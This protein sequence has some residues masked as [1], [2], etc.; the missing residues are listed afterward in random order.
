MAL[1]SEPAFPVC[2]SAL[3]VCCVLITAFG[4]KNYYGLPHSPSLNGQQQVKNKT[5]PSFTDVRRC[6]GKSEQ[7]VIS[8][9]LRTSVLTLQVGKPHPIMQ[10]HSV[11][12]QTQS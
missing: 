1:Q 6:Q 7:R 5:A 8:V 9:V 2:S 4:E 3:A 12:F 11:L 10:M